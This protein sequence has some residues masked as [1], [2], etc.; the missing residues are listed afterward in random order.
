M[1]SK[2]SS[3]SVQLIRRWLFSS[4]EN[5]F[6]YVFAFGP[7]VLHAHGQHAVGGVIADRLALGADAH[8]LEVEELLELDLTV[9]DACDF[10]HAHDPAYAT[11]KTRL[12]DDQVN[13]RSD[14]LADGARREVLT[15]LEDQRLQTHQ[16]LARVVGVDRRHRAIVSGVHGLEHVQRLSPTTLADDDPVGTH[17]ETALHELADGHRALAFDVGRA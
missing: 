9:F 6:R 15:C 16:A 3:K 17:T 7:Q 13:R 10:S 14:R 5:L 8:L 12:L 1:A 2:F 11:T 4:R